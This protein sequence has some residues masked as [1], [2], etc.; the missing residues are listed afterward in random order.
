MVSLAFCRM[1]RFS[2]P[3]RIQI[4]YASLHRSKLLIGIF[5]LPKRNIQ[6]LPTSISRRGLKN[7]LCGKTLQDFPRLL[8]DCGAESRGHFCYGLNPRH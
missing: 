4:S 3:G 5:M 8:H 6:S 2:I 7:I 1:L